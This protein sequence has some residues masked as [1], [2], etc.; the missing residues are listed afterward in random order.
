M[1]FTE[2]PNMSEQVWCDAGR[3]HVDVMS[4]D[5]LH[6]VFDA[7]VLVVCMLQYVM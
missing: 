7:S 2:Q 4:C 5:V 3:D 6:V 1:L